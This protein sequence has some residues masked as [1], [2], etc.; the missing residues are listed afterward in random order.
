MIPD[1]ALVLVQV[2]IAGRREHRRMDEIVQL[3]VNVPEIADMLITAA[4]CQS[5]PGVPL[6]VTSQR[7]RG[8]VDRR[9]GTITA[10]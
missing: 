6:A 4:R 5:C 9:D 10:R 2:A 8:S 1:T 7:M 3:G